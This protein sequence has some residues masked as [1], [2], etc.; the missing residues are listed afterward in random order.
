MSAQDWITGNWK[1][2]RSR[3]S[4]EGGQ[5]HMC[6]LGLGSWQIQVGSLSCSCPLHFVQEASGGRGWKWTTANE[7]LS[8]VGCG[9]AADADRLKWQNGKVSSFFTVHP[10]PPPT[11]V[12]IKVWR[13]VVI[14]G[15][16]HDRILDKLATRYLLPDS[17]HVW[18]ILVR[19]FSFGW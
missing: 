11:S 5:N 1:G 3:E 2:S 4:L 19:S 16:S 12:E 18:Y 13:F 7:Q 6:L 17:A 8:R 10:P 14:M 15:Y 9:P